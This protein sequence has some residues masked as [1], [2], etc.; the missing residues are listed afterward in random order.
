MLLYDA[1]SPAPNPRRVRMYLAEKGIEVP[2]QPVALFKGEHKSPEF[3][4]K[5]P[6]GQLPV[7]ELDD[8][9]MIGESLAICR[10]F[11]V[12]NPKP[13]LF[14]SGATEIAEIDMWLRRIELT[15][16]AALR[17]IWINTH[18]LTAAIVPHQYTDFGESQ[19]PVAVAAMQRFD[20][21]LAT[22]MFLGSDSYSIADISLLATIDFGIF[23]GM[24]IPET[25][26]ALRDWHSRASARTSATA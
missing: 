20:D 10:Y 8:G 26:T 4:A 3:L 12:L 11:E 13:T 7:L 5:Y 2:T 22:Q 23:I 19:R 24:T 16:G 1:P 21:A 14:G 9:R 25:M 18:P 17:Q 15:L 6:Y